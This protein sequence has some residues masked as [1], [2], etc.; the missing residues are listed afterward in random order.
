MKGIAKGVACT[1]LFT[2]LSGASQPRFYS[3]DTAS[4][5][6]LGTVAVEG[7]GLGSILMCG[8]C[9]AGGLIISAG[10][11]GSIVAASATPGSGPALVACVAAC[12]EAFS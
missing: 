6:P 12:V 5:P 7:Q 2:A 10:G 3:A 9:V 11:P 8:A 1:L 4:G